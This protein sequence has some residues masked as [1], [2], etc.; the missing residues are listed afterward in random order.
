MRVLHIK[1]YSLN[2]YNDQLEDM[3]DEA[4]ERY[5]NRKGGGTKQYKRAK[6]IDP[7][8]DEDLLEVL[9]IL[10]RKAI[11]QLFRFLSEFHMLDICLFRTTL[12]LR[13]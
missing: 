9:G 4:Y 3:L 7:N 11:Y 12:K 10:S 5:L 6:R 2:R 13:G 8:A 1:N